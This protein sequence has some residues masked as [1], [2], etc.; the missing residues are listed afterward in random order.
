MSQTFARLGQLLGEAGFWA[1]FGQ[2][3]AGWILGVLIAVGLGLPVGMLLGRIGLL[4][5]SSRLMVDFLRTIPSVAVIPLVTLLFGATLEM[6][7]MLVAF[8]SFWPFMLQVAYGVQDTDKVLVDTVRSFRLSTGRA[9]WYVFSP[10]ALPFAVTGLRIAAVTGL[11]LTIS[12]EILGSAP[13]LGLELA[14]AQTGGDLSLTY[15]Y[16]VFIGL[17]GVALNL[18]L[19][20]S[21]RRVLF[22]H[23]SVRGDAA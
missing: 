16:I 12:S 7:V 6:K 18:V 15:A 20:A 11:L 17:L 21:S 1:A 14:L 9:A 13:G 2:T 4:Y 19:N 22:W 8:G 5:R 3:M 10:S 23:A